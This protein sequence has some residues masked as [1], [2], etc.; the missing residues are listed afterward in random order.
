MTETYNT[1]YTR[2][3]SNVFFWPGEANENGYDVPKNVTP[4]INPISASATAS[5]SSTSA[6]PIPSSNSGPSRS[7]ES[8]L[9]MPCQQ[10]P[11]V[12]QMRSPAVL[13]VAQPQIRHQSCPALNNAAANLHLAA[14]KSCPTSAVVSPNSSHQLLL[15]VNNSS[16]SASTS[17]PIF[18]KSNSNLP[19]NGSSGSSLVIGGGGGASSAASAGKHALSRHSLHPQSSGKEKTPS[20]SFS[21]RVV[22]SGKNKASAPQ[23]QPSGEPIGRSNKIIPVAVVAAVPCPNLTQASDPAISPLAGPI[24]N[25][26]QY[27]AEIECH[28][29][30]NTVEIGRG[31][32]SRDPTDIRGKV[33][34][35]IVDDSTSYEN[36]NMDHIGRLTNEG[37]SQDLVV[38]ALGISRND[39]EMAREILNEFGTRASSWNK[40]IICTLSNTFLCIRLF[41]GQQRFFCTVL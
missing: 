38:R 22:V 21:T 19:H 3:T 30:E 15:S 2:L 37:F 27:L 6:H 36:I 31:L 8:C 17:S 34:D 18:P 11:V 13:Q 9:R 20:S 23:S 10:V 5:I 29:Y 24:N 16:S 28:N 12:A 25:P 39:I 14:P 26:S 4:S 40:L 41:L 35:L 1:V 7:A 33:R 32:R